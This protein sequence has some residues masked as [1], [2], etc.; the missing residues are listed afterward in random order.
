MSRSDTQQGDFAASSRDYWK[1]E[2]YR[3]HSVI[4]ATAITQ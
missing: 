1:F 3:H 4:S 2:G